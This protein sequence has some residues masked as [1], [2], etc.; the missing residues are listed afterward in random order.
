MANRAK[1]TNKVITPKKKEKMSAETKHNLKVGFGTLISNNCVVEAGRTF[2]WWIPLLLGILSVILALVPNFVIGLNTDVGNNFI[3]SNTYGFENGLVQFGDYLE[4]NKTD[5]S[6]IIK[7]KEMTVTGWE[8]DYWYSYASEAP[9]T[10]GDDSVV[11]QPTYTYG[12]EVFYNDSSVTGISDTDYRTRVLKNC[13]PIT[14]TQRTNNPDGST[15]STYRTNFIIFNKTNF[16]YGKFPRN[17]TTAGSTYIGYYDAVEDGYNLLSL[18]T[19]KEGTA[20]GSRAATDEIRANWK[21]FFTKS[22]ESTKISSVWSM[23]GIMFGVNTGV[24]LLF[25]FV[26]WLMTR[27]KMNPFR[28]VKVV[29]AFCMAGW[30]APSCAILSMIGFALTG[31]AAFIFIF[32]YGIRI[33]WMSMRALRPYDTGK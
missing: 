25:G 18:F 30:A 14:D 21:S 4:D 28:S 10:S 12:F 33:M 17:T 29:E 22:Y 5:V 11:V 32:L 31:Y 15:T 16:V 8:S 20:W 9:I 24:I 19:L 6:F 3:G 7:N 27:G 2:H 1:K 13:N 23:A 26:I